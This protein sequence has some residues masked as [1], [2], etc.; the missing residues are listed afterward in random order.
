MSAER[1]LT[2]D[3]GFLLSRASGAV[4]RSVSAALGPLGL[5]VR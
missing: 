1:P 4:A 3:L 5:R 2:D